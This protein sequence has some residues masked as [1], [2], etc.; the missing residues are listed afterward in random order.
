MR[1][2]ESLQPDTTPIEMSSFELPL[3]GA[4]GVRNAAAGQSTEIYDAQTDW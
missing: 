1:G 2:S 3:A 4:V